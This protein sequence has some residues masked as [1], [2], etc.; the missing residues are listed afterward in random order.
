MFF[1]AHESV[2]GGLERALLLAGEDGC[3]SL[4]IFTKNSSQWRDPML[5]EDALAAF[6]EQTVRFQQAAEARRPRPAG[7]RGSLRTPRTS[8]TSARTTR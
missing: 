3:D 2:A 5:G 1:G 4:Q 6:R 8:S 7:A